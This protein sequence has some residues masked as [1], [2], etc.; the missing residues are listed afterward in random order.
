MPKGIYITSRQVEMGLF[1]GVKYDNQR[2]S[3]VWYKHCLFPRAVK[4]KDKNT[5]WKP[6]YVDSRLSKGK[7]I[8]IYSKRPYVHKY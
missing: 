3:R 5:P 1:D 4:T 6:F 8:I 7:Q 2:F